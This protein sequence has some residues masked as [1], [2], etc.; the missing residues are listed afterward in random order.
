MSPYDYN[1]HA[2]L[3]TYRRPQRR[4]LVCSCGCEFLEEKRVAR[5]D[6]E[7]GVILGTPLATL[8]GE[9][10]F[11]VYICIACGRPVEP[12]LHFMGVD[13]GREDYEHVLRLFRQ[14][15]AKPE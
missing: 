4:A 6:G 2:G 12:P 10:P 15:S 5:F 9:P 13:P 8:D 14:R 1:P 11:L 7:Q 3:Q